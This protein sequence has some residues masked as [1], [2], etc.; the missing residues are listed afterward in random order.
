MGI[1]SIETK[2][3]EEREAFFRKLS[4]V[5]RRD[6][7]KLAGISAG[8]AA[9]KG[10]VNPHSFQLVD[11]ASADEGKPRFSFAYISD[12]H[13]YNRKLNDRF[14]RSILKAVD[15]VNALTPQPDFVL[16]GGDLAQLGAKDEL[17][18]GAQILKSVK[19]PVRMMVGE[20]DWFLDMGDVWK[21]LFG[22]P[23]YSFDHKGVHFVT[24]MSVNEKDFWT[25]RKMTPQQ[26]MN[27]VAGLDNGTQSR[28]EVGPQG[29]EWLK[30]DLAKID[31]K[32]PLVVFS[33]S[34][35][36]KYYRDWNFWTEDAD[37][38]QAILSKFESVTVIHG[39][40]HQLLSNHIGNIAFHG[41]LSTAWPWPYAPTGLP[42]LTVQMNRPDP[43]DNFDGCGDGR[44]EVGGSVAGLADS[45]YNLW[46]RNPVTVRASYLASNG[47]K[48][49][50]PATKL[51]SY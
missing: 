25:A 50:P 14:V 46:D 42:K 41:M 49:V 26:R 29:R 15:D 36:Y 20:H 18:L 2:H 5:S 24:L 23:Q 40:T 17:E 44:F 19:A 30:N 21:G 13:L 16:F 10:I 12:T 1:K 39:H 9:S 38:V 33:H 35:L 32:T 22:A 31:A 47:A 43:F 37:E 45:I 6:F 27:T 4:R 48:D 34:P 7:V 28:F 11:V 51:T 8:I 3:M